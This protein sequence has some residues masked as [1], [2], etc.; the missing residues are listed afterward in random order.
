MGMMLEQI[1]QVVT[2]K[3]G[4]K[5]RMR[6]AVKTGISRVRASQMEDNSEVILKFKNAADEIVGQDIDEF[7]KGG[8][9]V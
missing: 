2:Q 9:N 3:A 4:F 6:L 8:F 7:L 5:G 1:Y